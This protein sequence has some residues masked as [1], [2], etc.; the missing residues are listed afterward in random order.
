M[1]LAH[2]IGMVVVAISECLVCM[3]MLLSSSTHSPTTGRLREHEQNVHHCPGEDFRYEIEIMFIYIYQI[4][5]N[6]I[7]LLHAHG[8]PDLS[9]VHRP[10]ML[11]PLHF[12]EV[13]TI[14]S[15]HISQPLPCQ[16]P[17]LPWNCL[18]H[19]A[20][21]KEGFTTYLALTL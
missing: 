11:M 1:L 20:Q 15:V 4:K 18:D 7:N 14:I 9:T 21:G 3:Q 2:D 10:P 8:S 5:S 19:L 6:S 12:R 17:V 16:I 13:P